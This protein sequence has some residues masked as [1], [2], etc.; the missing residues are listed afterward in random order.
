[1]GK[2]HG[3]TE[4]DGIASDGAAVY[5]ASTQSLA[6][7]EILVHAAA[8]GDDYVAVQMEFPVDVR[9]ERIPLATLG[10]W[11]TENNSLHRRQVARRRN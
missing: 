4:A 9:I 3:Y 11:A 8:L 2:E 5:T 7:L 1:M 6:A 10:S